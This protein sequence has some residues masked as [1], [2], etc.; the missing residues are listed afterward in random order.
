MD[1]LNETFNN[2]NETQRF[3]DKQI[4]DING[5]D[6]QVILFADKEI[7]K[8]YFTAVFTVGESVIGIKPATNMNSALSLLRTGEVK[9]DNHKDV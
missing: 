6:V 1:L 4:F 5:V 3:V 9:Y 2:L 8:N 7:P